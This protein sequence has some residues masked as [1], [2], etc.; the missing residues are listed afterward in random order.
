MPP[1]MF[2]RRGTPTGVKPVA[3]HLSYKGIEIIVLDQHMRLPFNFAINCGRHYR[4]FRTLRS[5]Q[6]WIREV[7][8]HA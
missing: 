1:K 5:A 2:A 4:E 3:A 6:R 8:V 7:L